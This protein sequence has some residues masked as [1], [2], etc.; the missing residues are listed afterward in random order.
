MK[1]KTVEEFIEQSK[2]K[3]GNL[4]DYSLT[5]YNGFN[6]TITLICS[7]NH[8]FQTYPVSHLSAKSKG[9]CNECYNKNIFNNRKCKYTQES[10]IEAC[11]KVHSNKYDYSKTIYKMIQDKVT[12][13]CRVHGDFIQKASYHLLNKN[14]CLKCG[15]IITEQSNM[16]TQEKIKQKIIKFYR[17]H[18]NKYTYGKIYRDNNILWLEL[19]CPKHGTHI[20]RLFNHEKGHG[21][22]KCV[23]VRSNVQIQWLEYKM[24]RDGFIQHSDNTGEY[25]IPNTKLCVDGYNKETNTI[26]EFQGDFWHG[27]PFIYDLNTINK[28]LNVSFQELYNKTIEKINLM[29]SLGY[30]IVYIWENDWRK[31]VK[32]VKKLQKHWRRFKLV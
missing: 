27:N 19:I 18:N 26:Y 24:I 15:R 1:K 25:I 4:F 7:N 16:L 21:C 6:N 31:G 22:P 9:G 14:G 2:N 12:I 5:E 10:F 29:K 3:Y 32:S 28:K 17:I 30:N 23:S 11:N 8:I 13:T 20:T